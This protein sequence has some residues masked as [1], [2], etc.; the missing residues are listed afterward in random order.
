MLCCSSSMEDMEQLSGLTL[1]VLYVC[2]IAIIFLGLYAIIT[3]DIKVSIAFSFSLYIWLSS[4]YSKL[5]QFSI[6]SNI[7]MYFAF[8]FAIILFFVFMKFQRK[9]KFNIQIIES[10]VEEKYLI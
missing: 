1:L 2:L 9:P 5:N 3:D 8:I 7:F 6:I 10:N 4:V